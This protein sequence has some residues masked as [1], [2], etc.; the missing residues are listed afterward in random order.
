[1]PMITLLSGLGKGLPTLFALLVF[2]EVFSTLV[3]NVFG[4]A[5]Q[6]K[7]LTRLRGS[8]VLF[9]VLCICY[10]ISF[11]GFG[12]L[13]RILYPLFGQFVV[14]FLFMLL[15]RQLRNPTI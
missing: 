13:L 15:Y 12:P 10:L 7:Q 11:V 1:M 9:T 14:L 6:I 5:E 3:A 2:A 4:L 8:T